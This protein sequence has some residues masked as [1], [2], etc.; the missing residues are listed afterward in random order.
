[1]E[2]DEMD[3]G[4]VPCEEGCQQVGTPDYDPTKAREECKLFIE[5]LELSL[6]PPPEGCYFKVKANPHD[7]G[8]YYEVVCR[9]D[10][11]SE[12]AA[13]YA[14]RAESE[15]PDTWPESLKDR[16]PRR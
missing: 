12:E 15:G 16:V 3:I 6:G 1:M 4:P 9:Y 13:A 2:M 7:F 11:N 14:Y 5:A 8:S 10:T